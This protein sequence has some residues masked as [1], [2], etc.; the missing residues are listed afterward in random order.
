MFSVGII[1]TKL[2]DGYGYFPMDDGLGQTAFDTPTAPKGGSDGSA[3]DLGLFFWRGGYLLSRDW[4]FH[5]GNM[6]HVRGNV[7]N[8]YG[9]A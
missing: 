9:V 5:D 2:F 4:R 3:N 6:F 1:A 8:D 7:S